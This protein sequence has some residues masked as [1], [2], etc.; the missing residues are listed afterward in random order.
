MTTGLKGELKQALRLLHL[1][2]F[3]AHHM[4]QGAVAANESWSYDNYLMCLCEL[5]LAE[6]NERKRR[7]LL[8][9]SRLPEEK[10]LDSFERSRLKR[11]VE[12][13]FCSTS[14]WRVP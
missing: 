12:R 8:Q 14:R 2:A 10:T 13:Q 3:A 5:E 7:R 6:R 9:A 11:N 4:A 1:P